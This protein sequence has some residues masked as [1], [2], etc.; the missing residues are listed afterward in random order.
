MAIFRQPRCARMLKQ[1][2][3]PAFLRDSPTVAS[4]DQRHEGGLMLLEMTFEILDEWRRAIVKPCV[5]LL[6]LFF[7]RGLY[8]FLNRLNRFSWMT[9]EHSACFTQYLL[10]AQSTQLPKCA[11][12]L[13]KI[14]ALLVLK[15]LEMP[16]VLNFALVQSH[17]VCGTLLWREVGIA[18]C[19]DHL[20]EE[21][22]DEIRLLNGI[23][24]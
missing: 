24:F 17:Q 7:P 10:V 21:V 22:P 18:V 15:V 23:F 4:S 8:V 6:K 3:L 9:Q 14:G 16:A 11:D 20:K 5:I 12:R 1:L 2:P 13:L 19:P